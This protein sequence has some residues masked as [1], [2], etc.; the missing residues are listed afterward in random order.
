MQPHFVVVLSGKSKTG[1]G[2]VC[3]K[4]TDY[5]NT[6]HNVQTVVVT[7]AKP[8]KQQFATQYGVDYCLLLGSG[9]YKEKYRAA[10]IR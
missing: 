7:F 1:K 9:E 3:S 2:F 10:L 8:L 6:K 4:I 5:L